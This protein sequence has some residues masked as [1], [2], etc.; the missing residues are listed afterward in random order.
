M[1]SEGGADVVRDPDTDAD[2]VVETVLDDVEAD[3]SD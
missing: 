2:A 3:V 1:V